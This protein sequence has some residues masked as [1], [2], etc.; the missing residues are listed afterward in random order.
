MSPSTHQD[1]ASRSQASSSAFGNSHDH[2]AHTPQGMEVGSDTTGAGSSD[3]DAPAPRCGSSSGAH[4]PQHADVPIAGRTIPSPVT[5]LEVAPANIAP[6][7][8]RHTACTMTVRE[9]AQ[10]VPLRASA[11]RSWCHPGGGRVVARAGRPPSPCALGVKDAREISLALPAGEVRGRNLIVEL[12]APILER[13]SEVRERYDDKLYRRE[14]PR[15]LPLASSPGEG[16]RGRGG[17]QAQGLPRSGRSNAEEIAATREGVHVMPLCGPK[18]EATRRARSSHRRSPVGHSHPSRA[19]RGA[20]R[21][22]AHKLWAESLQCLQEHIASRSAGR[23]RARC[24]ALQ[25]RRSWSHP[26][27][28]FRGLIDLERSNARQARVGGRA[29]L[30]SSRLPCVGAHNPRDREV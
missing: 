7:M 26:R 21:K 3:P 19:R 17:E 18:L 23:S 8:T 16:L 6:R 2:A 20:R 4:R 15:R 29:T 13:R 11:R 14:L 5:P 9:E 24:E 22:R 28:R 12:V 25:S 1:I 30:A 27:L 10:H